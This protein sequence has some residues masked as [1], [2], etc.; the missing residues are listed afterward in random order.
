MSAER[1]QLAGHLQHI[2]E[3]TGRDSQ[4]A[5]ALTAFSPVLVAVAV[6][7]VGALAI[8]LAYREH[9][10]DSELA[11]VL[12][13]TVTSEHGRLNLGFFNSTSDIPGPHVLLPGDAQQVSSTT[14]PNDEGGLPF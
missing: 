4:W 3:M 5:A 12:V 13:E 6:L 2:G 14:T 11:E 7:S 10:G 8:W 1:A 9:A